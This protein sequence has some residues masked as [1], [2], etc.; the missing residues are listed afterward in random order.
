MSLKHQRSRLDVALRKILFRGLVSKSLG[1]KSFSV[2]LQYWPL[3]AGIGAMA[4][5]VWNFYF[6]EIYLPAAAP[7][8]LSLD[9]TLDSLSKPDTARPRHDSKSSLN[10]VLPIALSAKLVNNSGKI[11]H[12]LNPYWIAYGINVDDDANDNTRKPIRDLLLTI[13]NEFFGRN[14]HAAHR[15]YTQKQFLGMGSLLDDVTIIPKEALTTRK[16]IPLYNADY[17]AIQFIVVAPSATEI[18]S[19]KRV[20]TVIKF[21][22]I[23]PT[24]ESGPPIASL[25]WIIIDNK[26]SPRDSDRR[27][28]DPKSPCNGVAHQAPPKLYSEYNLQSANTLSEIWLK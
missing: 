24:E 9:V 18:P 25:C 19:D 28:S 17:E 1:V 7:A 21:K 2:L 3:L 11:I 8:N 20:T 13:Q 6:K 12:L 15:I 4:W 14:F 22:N 27:T 26:K 5:T 10:N 16:I 23:N